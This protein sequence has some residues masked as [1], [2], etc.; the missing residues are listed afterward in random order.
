MYFT[1][2]TP[3]F[4]IG[5]CFDTRLQMVLSVVKCISCFEYHVEIYIMGI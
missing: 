4:L 3:K 5:S 1:S 2:V